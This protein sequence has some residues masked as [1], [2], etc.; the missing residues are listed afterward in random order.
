[1]RVARPAA[2][3]GRVARAGK[4]GSVSGAREGIFWPKFPSLQEA[5]IL[6]MQYQLDD[7]QWWS[8]EKL[9]RYQLRQAQN[10][11]EHAAATVPFY[12]QRLKPVVGL[13][14]GG[15]TLERFRDIP[16]LVRGDIQNAGRDMISRKLP[17]THGTPSPAKT[18]GSSG[19]PMEF[20]ATAVTALM[21]GVLTMRGHFWHERD[22][23]LKNVNVRPPRPGRPAGRGRWSPAPW[24]GPDA[25]IDA[26]LP[27]AE[28][29]DAVIAENPVYLQSHP[30]V[31][32]GLILRT[33]ETGIH[34]QALRQVRTYGET[35]SPWLR[36]KCKAVWGVPITDNYSAEE[37][38]TIAHQCP[39][40]TNLHIQ[41]EAVLVEVLDDD[42]RPCR[43]G[44]AGRVVATAM[45]GRYPRRSRRYLASS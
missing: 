9:L 41:A 43:P 17:K 19:R 38:G 8:G 13:R 44:E 37:L 4:R 10:L 18:S 40:S 28:I 32:L 2:L 45:S 42:D 16:L 20:L 23:R 21:L 3:P 30:Y 11:I 31:V 36:D 27:M 14:P 6:A 15:L 25:L 22:L 34:P 1:M 5:T 12:R 35:L 26:R 39:E 29:F 24:S 33:E 7:S